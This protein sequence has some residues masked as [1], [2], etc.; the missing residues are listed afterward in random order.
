MGKD[1]LEWVPASGGSHPKDSV[2]A[3]YDSG[4]KV[5][6][7]RAHHEGCIIP[8]KLHNGHSSMYIPYNMAEVPCSDYEVL[9]GPPAAL[10]WVESSHGVIPPNSVQGGQEADG[11]IIYIGRA[12]HNGTVTVGKVHASHGCCY[13]SYG[14]EELNFKE[15][16]ILVKNKLGQFLGC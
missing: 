15:Y 16:E 3:G 1:K 14:G 2:R 10:S 6:V 5:Y 8:G 12:I 4:E 11:E 13:V 9:T 7:A